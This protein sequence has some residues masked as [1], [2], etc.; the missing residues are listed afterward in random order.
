MAAIRSRDTSPEMAVRRRLHSRGYRYR[1]HLRSLR[2]RPDLVFPRYGLVVFIHGCF[3]HGHTCRRAGKPRVNTQY[4]LPKIEGN[5]RRD[6]RSANY[7]RRCGWRVLTI[8]ECT[9]DEGMRR[10]ERLL[11]RL[12]VEHGQTNRS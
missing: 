9:L 2:G 10:V 6:R 4:W 1:L 3:W 8:R 11:E 12:R 7:L 5:R